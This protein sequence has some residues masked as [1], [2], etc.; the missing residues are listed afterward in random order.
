[1]WG[2]AVLF[3]SFV[4]LLLLNI[5]IAL[6][7]GISSIVTMFYLHVPISMLAMNIYAGIGKFTL[8]AIP[9]FVLAGCIMDKAG[10]SAKLINLA[11][12]FVGHKKGGLAFVC[13]ITSCFFAAISG[14]GPATVA[15]LGS[16]IIPAMIS[17]GY[18]VDMS[19]ALMSAA[20][21]IGIVI[22]P[23]IV[24][25]VYSSITGVSVGK[26]FMAGVIP[27]ILMGIALIIASLFV[28]KKNK[29]LAMHTKATWEER[30]R[31]FIDAFWG[32]LMPVI[33]LGG[34]YGG[35][36]TPTEAAAVSAAYGLFVGLVIYRSMSL[37]DVVDILKEASVQSGGIMLIVGC[38]SLF[39]WLCQSEGI[40]DMASEL[41]MSIGVN[42]TIFLLLITAIM[43][44]AGFFLEATSAL[45][46]FV[47]II[48]PVAQAFKYDLV[49]LGVILTVNMA[50]GQITPPVGVNLYVACN[51]GGINLKQISKSVFPF[52]IALII[53]LL[54]VTYIPSLSL[55][56]PTFMGMK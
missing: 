4:V 13:V 32:I 37:R 38:A 23:S 1:M 52:V 16:V 51:I 34:I 19:S 9:F 20:G 48:M 24:F 56:L 22:P 41:L 5:P 6:C 2:S 33:I 55:F 15:A 42:Q 53:V 8:L 14:S 44:V 26:I 21:S 30:W 50:I 36:F 49:A 46:I 17:A 10:I 12:K 7:L 11:D 18:G 3:A 28:L 40:S 35:L 31:A 27:G 45:Y 39:A 25:V 54:I 43:L 29:Q 47:P